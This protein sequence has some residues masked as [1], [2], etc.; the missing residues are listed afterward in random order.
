MNWKKKKKVKKCMSQTDN[1]LWEESFNMV[2][3]FEQASQLFVVV[4]SHEKM[5]E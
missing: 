1:Q 4:G 2:R 5:G 3:T